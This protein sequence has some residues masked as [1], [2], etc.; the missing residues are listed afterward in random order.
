MTTAREPSIGIRTPDQRLR[1]F[2]SSTLAELADERAAVARAIEALRLTPVLFELGARPHPPRELYRA[3]LAQSDVF[4]GLYWQRYGWI[5]PDME[6][7]GLEDEF[8]LSDALPRLIYVKVPAPD[9]E[10]RLAAMIEQLQSEGTESYRP[11]SD[12]D[13]LDRLVRDDLAVMM[14]ERF[15]VPEDARAELARP[16]RTLPAVPTSLLGRDD[17]IDEV[18]KLLTPPDV[19]FVTLTGPGGIG[20]TRLAVAVAERVQSDYAEGAAFVPLASITQPGFVMPRIAA[21]IGASIEGARPAIDAIADHLGAASLLLVL[22]NLEQ[23]VGVATELDELLARCPGIEIITTSRS[24]LRLRAECEYPVTPLS[25]PGVDENTATEHLASVPAVQLFVERA[26]AIRHDFA[27]TPD[28]AAAIAEICR[29]LDGLPLAIELAAARVRLLDPVTL[30]ARL[31][32]GLDALGSGPVD[33]PERQ[34]TLRATVEWSIGL[35]DDDTRAVLTMLSVFVDGWTIEAAMHVTELTDD[36]TLDLLDALAGHSLVRVEPTD[37]G[38][39][40][41]MLETVR[42]IT[43]E[44]LAER[45]DCG[46]I[47]RRHAQFFG[48][49]VLNSGWPH[50]AGMEWAERLRLDEG[51]VRRAVRWYFAH[52]IAPLARIFRILWLDWQIRD[53]MPEGHA[54]LDDLLARADDLDDESHVQVLLMAAVTEGE[55]GNHAAAASVTTRLEQMQER[56]DDPYLQAA[57]QLVFSWRRSVD[58]IE[59]AMDAA[60][61]ALEGFRH[62]DEQGVGG[63][64]PFI[65]PSG[66]LTVGMIEVMMGRYDDARAHLRE[67][68]EQ[69]DRFDNAFLGSGGRAQLASLAVTT[70]DLDEAR[71]LLREAMDLPDDALSTHPLSFSLIAAA[72]L[73]VAEDNPRRAA[74]ALGATEAIRERAGLTAWASSQPGETELAAHLHEVLGANAFAAAFADGTALDRTEAISLVR[75]NVQPGAVS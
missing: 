39:R 47:E 59:G 55:V 73:A 2:V 66:L 27:F 70:G 10:D 68:V 32:R 35:L 19:R 56:I 17:D 57:S 44:R 9:R 64:A 26:H 52:D 11:F 49:L 65:T 38:P 63:F 75:D 22:D 13:E 18:V 37:L 28:N 20:K 48:D 54:W 58:D 46:E 67:V 69:G 14:S 40:F 33:L 3:Y 25:V 45:T 29:R 24:V 21:A 34:R 42:E 61:R 7:S 5:G 36:R 50:Q 43:A 4:V 1:V 15:L 71:R 51:N 6:I 31:E 60:Q 8:Q 12:P 41:R 62:Q 16:P 53:R 23:V 72:R 74:L 30:L